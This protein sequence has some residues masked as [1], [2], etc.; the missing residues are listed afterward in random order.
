MRKWYQVFGY[1]QRPKC[2]FWSTQ[3]WWSGEFI[4]FPE[5]GF[6][7]KGNVKNSTASNS[8]LSKIFTFPQETWHF[9]AAHLMSPLHPTACQPI[10]LELTEFTKSPKCLGNTKEYVTEERLPEASFQQQLFSCP[11]LHSPNWTLTW[12]NLCV[13]F[14]IFHPSEQEILLIS[15]WRKKPLKVS[16]NNEIRP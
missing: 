12:N 11:V 10:S 5:W 4:P 15:A 1:F 6:L 16:N 13:F 9:L 2:F 8:L 7:G 3:L 14:K